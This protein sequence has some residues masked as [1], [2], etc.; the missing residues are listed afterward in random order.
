[1]QPLVPELAHGVD[2]RQERLAFGRQAV[3][4]PWGGLGETLP[5]EDAVGLECAEPF[6][7]RS[8]ADALARAL[9]LREAA[10]PFGQVV[11]EERRPLRADDLGRSG[12]R[13]GA[14][15]VYLVHG[16]NGHR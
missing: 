7:E 6:G 4:D 10:R 11:D 3:L 14:R 15:L 5:L 12:D 13:A 8:W 16:A 1:M 9:E 2:D